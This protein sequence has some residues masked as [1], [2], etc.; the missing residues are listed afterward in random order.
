MSSSTTREGILNTCV[1][2]C[3]CF[4]SILNKHV[5]NNPILMLKMNNYEKTG[6][7]HLKIN[8]QPVS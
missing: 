4:S 3:L 5:L 8:V 2:K 7:C 6:S 1:L